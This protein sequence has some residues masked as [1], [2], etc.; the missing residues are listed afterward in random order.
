MALPETLTPE[1]QKMLDTFRRWT[2]DPDTWIGCF[3]NVALDSADLGRKVCF[4][5]DR[6]QWDKATVGKDKAPDHPRYGLGWRYIL[7]V[8][9]YDPEEALAFMIAE[10]GDE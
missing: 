3:Q 1:Q 8:K 10:P 7:Q 5:Y 9:T 6:A 4:Q 2:S